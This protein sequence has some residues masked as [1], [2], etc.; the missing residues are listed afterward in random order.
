M[1]GYNTV[2]FDAMAVVSGLSANA[3]VILQN[4]GVKII[5]AGQLQESATNPNYLYFLDDVNSL[6]IYIDDPVLGN[7]WMGPTGYPIAGSTTLRNSVPNRDG[8]FFYNTDTETVEQF[9]GGT[10]QNPVGGYSSVNAPNYI[11]F[12]GTVNLRVGSKYIATSMTAN[13][14]LPNP[15]GLTVGHSVQVLALSTLPIT[16]IDGPTV[17]AAFETLEVVNPVSGNLEMTTSV[18]MQKGVTYEFVLQDAGKWVM[19][20]SQLPTAVT[21]YDMAGFDPSKYVLRSAASLLGLDFL[22][23]A[24]AASMRTLLE[25]GSAATRNVGEGADELV[26]NTRLQESLAFLNSLAA[27]GVTGPGR[28]VAEGFGNLGVVATAENWTTALTGGSRFLAGI[29]NSP[30]E[31]VPMAGI[32]AAGTDGVNSYQLQIAGRGSRVFGR[33]AE[34]AVPAPYF[35]FQTVQGTTTDVDTDVFGLDAND[36]RTLGEWPVSSDV[37]NLPDAVDGVLKVSGPQTPEAGYQLVQEFLP[38]SNTTPQHFYRTCKAGVYSPWANALTTAGLGTSA[39]RDVGEAAGNVQLVGSFGGPTGTQVYY[40]S[41]NRFDLGATYATAIAALGLKSAAFTAIG[42]GAGEVP[43]K[44]VLDVRLGTSGNLGTAAQ[45]PAMTS[46]TDV[47]TPN[48]LM[49]R[50]AFG[51]GTNFSASSPIGI[52]GDGQR[53]VIGLLDVTNTAGSEAATSVFNGSV[54]IA[55]SN[56]IEAPITLDVQMQKKYNQAIASMVITIRDGYDE[57]QDY[58]GIRGVHFTYNGRRYAGIDCYISVPAKDF[59]QTSGSWNVGFQ[60]FVVPIYNQSTNTVLNTEIWNSRSLVDTR[61]GRPYT[62]FNAIGQVTTAFGRPAGAIIESGSNANGVYVRYANGTQICYRILSVT[63]PFLENANVG[64]YGWSY[65]YGASTWNYP[66]SFL[67]TPSIGVT[68]SGAF[69][70][71]AVGANTTPSSADIIAITT[72]NIATPAQVY[73]MAIGRWY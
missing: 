51:L 41:G 71:G 39:S 37:T 10:W 19:Y 68:P 69:L 30:L 67:E 22:A 32:S 59:I 17:S 38:Y 63:T 45:R 36:Y 61:V 65:W 46:L 42:S 24:D 50:G 70:S 1:S 52:A 27:R 40:H 57:S 11:P 55:R 53:F 66:A 18:V 3:K 56:G 25:L 16:A 4:I 2:G 12:V 34:G 28:F 60:P 44:A 13:A 9:I 21:I 54:T 20:T 58:T 26:D 35:E 23:Q 48:A 73:V 6:A 43:D 49:P 64:T 29:T 15:A 33:T 47:T 31:G 7:V 14:V 62:Q 5:T 8:A 72:S